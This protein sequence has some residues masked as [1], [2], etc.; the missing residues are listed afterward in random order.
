MKKRIIF[1]LFTF[2]FLVSCAKLQELLK[3]ADD[4]VADTVS[5]TVQEQITK[6]TTTISGKVQLSGTDDYSGVTVKIGKQVSGA[7]YHTAAITE[8]NGSFSFSV[9][10]E[11]KDAVSKSIKEQTRSIKSK[12]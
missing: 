6:F 5:D 4:K 2:I 11:T 3:S 8:K 9:K 1:F 7:E 10:S 12:D